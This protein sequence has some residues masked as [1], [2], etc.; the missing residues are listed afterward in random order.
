MYMVLVSWCY[1]RNVLAIHASNTNSHTRRNQLANLSEAITKENIARS[2][3]LAGL[4]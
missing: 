4:E 1:R 2:P 3:R